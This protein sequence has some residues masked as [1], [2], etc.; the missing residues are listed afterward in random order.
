MV[1]TSKI[2]NIRIDAFELWCGGLLRV[3][4]TA[5]WSNQSILKEI[6]LEYSLEGLILKLKLQYF[7]HLMRRADSFEKTL[8]LGKIEGGRRRGQTEDEMVG[9]HHRCNGHE[10]EKAAGVGEGQGS[11]ACCSL[12]GRKESDMTGW[13][14]NNSALWESL[15][16]RKLIGNT[17]FLHLSYSQQKHLGFYSLSPRK[18]VFA[19]WSNELVILKEII[20]PLLTQ[21]SSHMERSWALDTGGSG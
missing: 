11:L 12:W 3:P 13:L 17:G 18:I 4:W 5:R 9:W 21:S 15:G 14:N 10:F 1:K 2:I 8:M 20:I 6:N 16:C 7:G 19:A